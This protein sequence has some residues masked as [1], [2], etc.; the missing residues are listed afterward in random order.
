MLSLMVCL[1]SLSKMENKL[2]V[3]EYKMPLEH[4][5]RRSY[6]QW[7]LPQEFVLYCRTLGLLQQLSD[8]ENTRAILLSLG[9]L[10]V[11]PACQATLTPY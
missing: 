8:Q 11:Q 2:L 9:S 10:F 3:N 6:G 7:E 4:Q 1:Q 5:C